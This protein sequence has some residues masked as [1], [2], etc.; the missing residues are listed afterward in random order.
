[1][2]Q[3]AAGAYSTLQG[4]QI[5]AIV[6]RIKAGIAGRED[7]EGALVTAIDVRRFLRKF[8]ERELFSVPVL[9]YQELG[10]D[11]QLHVLGNIDMIGEY[12]DA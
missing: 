2:R 12:D 3:T 1:V 5:E 9:S 7:M 11:V 10:D 6:A 4:D 8:L